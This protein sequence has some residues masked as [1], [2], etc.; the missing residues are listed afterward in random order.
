MNENSQA[1]RQNFDN[2]P[3]EIRNSKRF[4]KVGGDK[5][6]RTKDW[7]NPDNQHFH[8]DIHGIAG[9]DTSGHGEYDDF[10]FLDFDHVLDDDGN[11]VTAEAETCYNNLV[12]EFRGI[13]V[14]KSISGTGLHA[15][16]APN[17]EN[18]A[19]TANGRNGVLY[20]SDDRSKS[21][22]K[23][24]LFYRTGGR[25]CLVT[26][27]IFR[28]SGEE[29]PG[30]VGTGEDVDEYFQ[31]LLDQIQAQ[32]AADN[33]KHEAETKD[34]SEDLFARAHNFERTENPASGENHNVDENPSAMR[35]ADYEDDP[36]E[37]ERARVLAMLDRIDVTTLDDTD[38]LAVISAAKN[39]GV[40]YGTVDAF[41]R[42]DPER[43]DEKENQTRWDSLNNPSF[44]IETLHGIAKRFGYSEHDF[45]K[46]W[47][48]ENPQFSKKQ[49]R[50]SRRKPIP[51]E[52]DSAL[53]LTAQQKKDLFCG[54]TFDLDYSER[55]IYLYKNQ[56]RYISDAEK[57]IHYSGSAW[58]F[59]DTRNSSI[60]PLAIRAANAMI[61]AATND[62]ERKIASTFRQQK[63]ITAAVILLK[64]F[65]NIIIRQKDLDKNPMLL[66]VAN[67]VIDLETG[68]LMPAAPELLLSKQSPAVYNPN[69][70]SPD[71]DNF[72]I[73]ILPDERTRAAVLRFLGYCLT[74]DVREEKALFIHG[75]GGNGK[76]VLMRSIMKVLADYAVPMN[77]DALLQHRNEKDGDSPTPEFAK[78]EGIRM[79]FANE[80]PQGK[81]LDAAHFKDLSGGDSIAIRRLHQES[82][83]IENPTHKLILCGQHL[84]DLRDSKDIG[85]Q[86]RLL[87]AK[88]TE[89]FTGKKCDPNLK[90]RL[91]EP[92]ALTGILTVLVN[93][94]LAWQRDG[95]I[96][97]EAMTAEKK[98]YLESN[99]FI[100]D[101]IAEFCERGDD[102]SIAR[103]VF[104]ARLKSVYPQARAIGDRALTE[105]IKKVEGVEY[106]KAHGAYKIFGVDWNDNPQTKLFEPPF[107]IRG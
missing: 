34:T 41:N 39:L 63:K 90:Y 23:L 8:W 18:F 9:F 10:L 20:L 64:G 25:Y 40:D 76:G 58:N 37:Y 57:W 35:D 48:Q 73:Q 75:G 38:W 5:V 68:K 11:F 27:N 96:I 42:R 46:Q 84:P 13:Y 67:G 95:L 44:G 101:F 14:E 47:Y 12:K 17:P 103:A 92:D 81:N 107:L 33:A 51:A 2:M 106:R 91:T 104:L 16:L 1:P 97:S 65:S 24:E 98:A 52:K 30:V 4:F 28:D 45:K 50:P 54:D 72:M 105:M 29:I 22:P 71:F 31:S 93:E 56:I 60:Y 89:T 88:F 66:N 87:I 100:T 86:R 49:H 26:G 70:R 6:P 83:V 99:D 77:I 59:N 80:I 61:A 32:I 74:G 19:P 53:T 36:P 55:L 69:Y 43:Y 3:S 85:L 15:F 102:K 79:A 94:C 78:L 62:H 82:S 21:A 7:S